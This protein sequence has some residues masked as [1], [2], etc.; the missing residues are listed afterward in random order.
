MTIL[1]KIA[2]L[3]FPQ[4]WEN[5]QDR[6]LTGIFNPNSSDFSNENEAGHLAA[7][8]AAEKQGSPHKIYT[9]FSDLGLNKNIKVTL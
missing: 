4:N 8:A 3:L 7:M 9:Q 2:Y 1:N 6:K 5:Y